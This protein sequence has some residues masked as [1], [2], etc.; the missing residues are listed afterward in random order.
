MYSYPNHIPLPET[1]IRAIEAALEP[2]AFERIY[3]AWWGTVIPPTGA[4]SCAAPRS[5]TS[6]R[7][8]G[9]C[10]EMTT[11]GVRILPWPF[12]SS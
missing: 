9:N 8:T 12:W 1:S 3:G 5:A 4:G 10:H 6:T 7:C 2:F 11:E